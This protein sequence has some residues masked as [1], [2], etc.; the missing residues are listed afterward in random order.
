[1]KKIK[2]SIGIYI[3][4]NFFG[5]SYKGYFILDINKSYYKQKV[6]IIRVHM[7]FIIQIFSDVAWF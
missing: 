3:Y 7:Y 4:I 1:M 2:Q 5:V 6:L